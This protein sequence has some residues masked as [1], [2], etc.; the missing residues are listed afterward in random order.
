MPETGVTGQSIL[1]C[2]VLFGVLLCKPSL[3]HVM[4]PL[5]LPQF[6]AVCM[7]EVS[8]FVCLCEWNISLCLDLW[9]KCQYHS[10]IVAKCEA[11]LQQCQSMIYLYRARKKANQKDC[12][13]CETCKHHWSFSLLYCKTA[14]WWK[15]CWTEYCKLISV[16]SGMAADKRFSRRCT[17]Q[18]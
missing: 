17:K 16:C 10:V 7:S 9:N 13:G 4:S 3:I 8:I 18:T 1:L 15:W 2:S 14:M 11:G 5:L 12:C 6:V